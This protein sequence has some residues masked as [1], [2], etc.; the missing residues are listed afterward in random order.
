[1]LSGNKGECGYTATLRIVGVWCTGLRAWTVRIL[2]CSVSLS[3]LGNND[4][5]SSFFSVIKVA[6]NCGCYGLISLPPQLQAV[7]IGTLPLQHSV[8]L[9]VLPPKD[10]LIPFL[11]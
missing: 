1:M 4:G 8:L 6:E 5:P 9:G 7:L 11:E 3:S 2:H 10:S